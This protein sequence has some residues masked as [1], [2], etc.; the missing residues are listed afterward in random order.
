M[1]FFHHAAPWRLVGRAPVKT[2]VLWI[3]GTVNQ[4]AECADVFAEPLSNSRRGS[5][6]EPVPHT[7]RKILPCG[8]LLGRKIFLRTLFTTQSNTLSSTAFITAA[9]NVQNAHAARLEIVFSLA[10]GHARQFVPLPIPLL[11]GELSTHDRATNSI[12]SNIGKSSNISSLLFERTLRYR[13]TAFV[14]IRPLIY[15]FS[16][17]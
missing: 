14:R 3:A 13:A 17:P 9:E 12:A 6:A 4:T 7:S 15:T 11:G 2:A 5:K 10:R 8:K 16:L 1:K